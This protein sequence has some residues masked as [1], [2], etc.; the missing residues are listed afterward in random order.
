METHSTVAG[1]TDF[2]VVLHIHLLSILVFLQECKPS[3][4]L[5][6]FHTKLL[7]LVIASSSR[8]SKHGK[9]DFVCF[10]T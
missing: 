10:T 8:Y 3:F 1:V 9:N 4:S 5:R 2:A 6:F 7:P